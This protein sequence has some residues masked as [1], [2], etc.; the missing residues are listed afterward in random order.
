MCF[1]VK[2]SQIFII[3]RSFV[4]IEKKWENIYNK[5]L[6]KKIIK[7]NKKWNLLTMT[8]QRSHTQKYTQAKIRKIIFWTLFDECTHS[9]SY[10][11]LFAK[12]PLLLLYIINN[13]MIIKKSRSF[14]SNIRFSVKLS[15]DKGLCSILVQQVFFIFSRRQLLLCYK[16]NVTRK[17]RY[18]YNRINNIHSWGIHN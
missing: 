7:K 15:N 5:K 1:L 9:Y 13:K 4:K 18:E 12:K 17:S 6:I 10:C 2:I 8:T 3:K 14:T 11:Y 16:R